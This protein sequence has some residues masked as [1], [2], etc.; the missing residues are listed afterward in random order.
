M[1]RRILSL[2]DPEDQRKVANV[3]LAKDMTVRQA[4]DYVKK[5][6]ILS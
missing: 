6:A 2:K 4:E 3:I 5:Y 1:L